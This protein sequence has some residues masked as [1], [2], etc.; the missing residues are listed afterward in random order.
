MIK[1]VH[2]TVNKTTEKTSPSLY[3]IK[4]NIKNLTQPKGSDETIVFNSGIRQ[5]NNQNNLSSTKLAAVLLLHQSCSSLYIGC[6]VL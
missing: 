6:S 3:N 5:K 1:R 2:V 4:L